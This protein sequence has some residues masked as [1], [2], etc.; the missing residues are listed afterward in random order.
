MKRRRE[1]EYLLRRRAARKSD[2]LRYIQAEQALER[3]RD[4]RTRQ[5]FRRRRQELA[6]Q[7]ESSISNRLDNRSIVQ[8]IHFL[9]QRILRKWKS[10]VTLYIQHAEFAKKSKSHKML[11]RIYA[12][13]LQVSGNHTQFLLHPTFI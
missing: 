13:A 9:F 3:L 1:S 7:G 5:L 10:D 8:H 11:G 2:F 12:E 4:L 6:E